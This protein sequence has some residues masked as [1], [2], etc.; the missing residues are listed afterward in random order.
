MS[1]YPQKGDG[2]A[3]RFPALAPT[4]SFQANI[5]KTAKP[6]RAT[7]TKPWLH[8]NLNCEA[9]LHSL[10]RSDFTHL[11]ANFTLFAPT[12]PN[13]IRSKP[14]LARSRAVVRP[15]RNTRFFKAPT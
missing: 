3:W 11:E 8:L 15:M 14:M 12:P 4:R 7:R 10:P 13:G 2:T 1:R 5:P 6:G 9:P